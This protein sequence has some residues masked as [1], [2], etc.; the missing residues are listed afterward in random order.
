MVRLLR[1][2]E[3]KIVRSEQQLPQNILRSQNLTPEDIST[4]IM[5]PLQAYATA[6]IHLF[7]NAAV[8]ISRK[9]WIEDFQAPNLSSACSPASPDSSGSEQLSAE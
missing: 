3:A 6:N 9:G 7:R 1:F 2:P 8:C 4:V 5:T